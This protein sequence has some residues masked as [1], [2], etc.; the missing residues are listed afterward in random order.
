MAAAYMNLFL[1]IVCEV[2]A[3]SCL[4]QS[5]QFTRLW[6]TLAMAAGYAAPCRLWSAAGWGHKLA[7]LWQSRAGCS[8]DPCLPHGG[9]VCIAAPEAPQAGQGTGGAFAAGTGSTG[10]GLVL[11]RR[12]PCRPAPKAAKP[13]RRKPAPRRGKAGVS[14]ALA[15][16]LSIEKKPSP[17]GS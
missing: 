14:A 7:A 16:S 15:L 4:K 3:T 8:P 13:W 11:Y 12:R 1:A 6:P 2:I 10:C 5:E 9:T 17:E